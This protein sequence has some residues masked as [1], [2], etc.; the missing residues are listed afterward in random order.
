MYCIKCGK[1]LNETDKFCSQCGSPVEEDEFVPAFKKDMM[2]EQPVA[3]K[4][5]EEEAEPEKA[6][7]HNE[8]DWNL[9][10]YPQE[11]RVTD[12]INF[13][14]DS[15]IGNDE[16]RQERAFVGF[17]SENFESETEAASDAGLKPDENSHQDNGIEEDNGLE[18]DMPDTNAEK[19]ENQSDS[20]NLRDESQKKVDKFFTFNRKNAEFQA[21]LDKEFARLRK[22]ESERHGTL[23]FDEDLETGEEL[24]ETVEA[25]EPVEAETP[26]AAET[27]P[28]SEKKV[29]ADIEG[30]AEAE[31]ITESEES[32]SG[33]TAAEAAEIPDYEEACQD[34]EETPCKDL[35][36]ELDNE[37]EKELDNDL[38]KELDKNLENQVTEESQEELQNAQRIE[39]AEQAAEIFE[40]APEDTVTQHEPE[41]VS[42]ALASVPTGVIVE[43]KTADAENKADEEPADTEKAAAEK[44]A[45]AEKVSD[46]KVLPPS[47][48]GEKTEQK[49]TFDDVFS[50]DDEDDPEPKTKGKGFL[51]F[52]A[53]ILL[54]LIIAELVMIGIQYF[55]P[56]SQAAAAINQ[57]YAK[58]VATIKGEKE[59]PAPTES[60]AAEVI[61]DQEMIQKLID[62]NGSSTENIVKIK[63]SSEAVF[64][65]NQDYGF[66]E[67][68]KSYEFTDAPWYT[69]DEGETVTYGQEIVK[70]IAGYYD[71][72]VKQLNG[73]ENSILDY[74]DQTSDFYRSAADKSGDDGAEYGI[75]TLEIGQIR[76]SGSGFYVRVNSDLANSLETAS[77]ATESVV[78]IEPFN[79]EMK[80]ADIK[81]L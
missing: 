18:E 20:G 4:S 36:K 33:D 63:Y 3:P 51:K 11:G 41:L 55:A 13:D 34:V 80:I 7:Y 2:D 43:R 29:N 9:E 64:E 48:E 22:A 30:Q 6:C 62:E 71:N 28:K 12:D 74:V 5:S 19:S 56:D 77:V 68:N 65:E 26:I 53:A 39:T 72:Y 44:E 24:A 59:A 14:W 38:E 61:Q 76:T 49:L 16:R 57:G 23:M 78:Y 69:N 47:T 79:K 1:Q 15:V 45:A 75:N 54:I 10:G 31:N 40:D 52:I 81:D 37:L 17:K 67:F 35:E 42:V 70:C 21:L 32:F 73:K 25:A 50:D 46:K 66:E 8:F 60:D 58:V 27:E